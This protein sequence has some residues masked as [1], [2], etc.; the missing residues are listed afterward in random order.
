MSAT[1]LVVD[2][3]ET[4]LSFMTP[5]LRDAGYNVVTAT[6]LKAAHQVVDRGDADIIVL[7]VQLHRHAV[8]G[9]PRGL[10]VEIAVAK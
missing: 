7:D 4:A 5:L 1:I 2:D 9:A 3:E 6:T 10:G 8:R